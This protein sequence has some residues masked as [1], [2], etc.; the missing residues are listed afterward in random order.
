MTAESRPL[1]R[2]QTV[3]PVHRVWTE[4]APL[5]GMCAVSRNVPIPKAGFAL[6]DNQHRPNF[7]DSLEPIL[8][9]AVSLEFLKKP[10]PPSV[11]PDL[12]DIRAQAQDLSDLTD[13]QALQ[14]L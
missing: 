13:R 7:A 4:A 9:I 14:F 3:L 5:G 10:C 11:Q 12:D 1:S 8:R 2:D 6:N